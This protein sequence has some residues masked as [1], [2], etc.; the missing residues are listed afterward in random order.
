MLKSKSITTVYFTSL[1][2]QAPGDCCE[3]VNP[4]LQLT[5]EYS[6][7]EDFSI[8]PGTRRY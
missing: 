1:Q 6:L 3:A 7:G 5:A 4:D 8:H 2:K